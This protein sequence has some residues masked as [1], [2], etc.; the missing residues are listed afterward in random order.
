[1]DGGSDC[2]A[3]ERRSRHVGP[4]Y[5]SKKHETKKSRRK[6]TYQPPR[7]VESSMAYTPPTSSCTTAYDRRTNDGGAEERTVE[8]AILC[9]KSRTQSN[10]AARRTAIRRAGAQA[11]R[12]GRMVDTCGCCHCCRGYVRHIRCVQ[13]NGEVLAGWRYIVSSLGRSCGG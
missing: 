5:W 2:L 4:D 8:P 1:L 13:S 7:G 9:P 12:D 10:D 6:R 3:A 11:G